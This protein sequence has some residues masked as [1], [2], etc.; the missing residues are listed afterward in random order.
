MK[1]TNII[2]ILD[3]HFNMYFVWYLKCITML[4]PYQWDNKYSSQM[5]KYVSDTVMITMM[6]TN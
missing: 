6:L 4:N 5:Y 2:I 3:V 1:P